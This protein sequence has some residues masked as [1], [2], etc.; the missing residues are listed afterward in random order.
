[1]AI[2]VKAGAALAKPGGTLAN[3]LIDAGSR[4]LADYIDGDQVGNKPQTGNKIEG[5]YK[6]L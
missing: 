2:L 5:R 4:A 1:M 3:T 6:I